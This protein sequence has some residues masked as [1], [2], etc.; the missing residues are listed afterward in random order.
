MSASFD[1]RIA[2]YNV[3][4][5]TIHKLISLAALVF[6]A[7]TVYRINQSSTL[8]PLELTT[9]MVTGLLFIGTITTGGLLSTDKS[10]PAAILIIH[11]ILPF[12][13]VIATAAT[14]YL[15]FSRN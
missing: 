10:M 7:I 15:L 13:T 6:L 9:G 14:L 4:I 11:Q 5:L 1:L 12:L 8:N 2:A 3:I